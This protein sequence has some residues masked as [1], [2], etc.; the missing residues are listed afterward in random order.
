MS[1]G[2]VSTSIILHLEDLGVRMKNEKVHFE[3]SQIS[4]GQMEFAGGHL[5]SSP[6]YH[7]RHTRVR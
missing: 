1:L 3:V 4:A 7:S 6:V 5:E 2:I